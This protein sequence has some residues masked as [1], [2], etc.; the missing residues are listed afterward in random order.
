MTSGL[1]SAGRQLQSLL[2][3]ELL[4][5]LAARKTLLRQERLPSLAVRTPC[6]ALLLDLVD[7]SVRVKSEQD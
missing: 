7:Q 6:L 1:F 5:H 4:P 3:A 2:T